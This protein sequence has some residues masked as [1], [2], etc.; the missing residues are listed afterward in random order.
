M[1][2]L[3]GTNGQRENFRVVGKPNLPGRFSYAM[4]TG[5]AKFGSDY[6]IP[7]MLHAKF[8]RSPYANARIINIDI[9]K[10]K[11]VP[12]IVD[13]FT[14]KDEEIKN[15]KFHGFGP[16][17]PLLGNAAAQEGAEVGAVVVAGR[18]VRCINERTHQYDLS[19]NQRFMHLKVGFKKS[20]NPALRG[21]C[22][23]GKIM[24]RTS[25]ERTIRF[26]ST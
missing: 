8:L 12:G 21:R 2:D 24:R 3:A 14:W 5:L 9:S 13:I 10:A 7:G 11:A 1:A 19:L 22:G 26:T 16:P 25:L 6:V 20:G 15:M 17:G 4:A 23:Y 18:P